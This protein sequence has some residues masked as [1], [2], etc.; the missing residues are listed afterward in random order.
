[1]AVRGVLSYT[2]EIPDLQEGVRFYTDAGLIPTIEGNVAHF[3]C[4]GQDRDSVILLG[5][6]PAKRLHHIA[7]RAEGLD[8]IAGKVVAAGGKVVAAGEGLEDYG[9]W[10][11]DPHGML[12]HLVER[13]VDPEPLAG[14][15]FEINA[16]GRLV[17]IRRSAVKPRSTYDDVK[18]L[19]LGHV[20][21][22]TPDVRR[23]VRFMC[24]ALGMGLADHA[25]EMIA[26]C[27]ARGGSEHH[28]VAFAKSPGVGFHHG[29]FQVHDPDE[30]GRGGRALLARVGRGDWGFGRHT[31]GSNYFHYIQDPWGSWFEY[32]S[33][34]DYIDDY[35]LWT[36]TNYA[37][38]DSLDSWGPKMPHDFVHNY[39]VTSS[40]A[41][42]PRHDYAAGGTDPCK[43]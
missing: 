24:E 10:V 25:Q 34:M 31:I 30:V 42:G 43:Q 27:C 32:Y 19:R 8:E 18:P 1:M 12:I 11:T 9:L 7:L 20:L 13:P 37:L 3:T 4:A 17:R 39:E 22:F 6:R 38:E 40:R 2:L 36:P 23:S 29:S 15:A 26:F 16:P 14:P 35:E 5:G 21:V 33:D 28:V 41:L